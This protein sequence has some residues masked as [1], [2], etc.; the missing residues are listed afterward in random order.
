MK[1]GEK[2]RRPDFKNPVCLYFGGFCE[3]IDGLYFDAIL[4]L[5]DVEAND[6][7]E[8]TP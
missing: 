8:A 3:V 1:M 4:R 6:W 5:E 2:M 7:E